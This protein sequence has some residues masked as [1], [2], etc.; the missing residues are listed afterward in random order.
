[1]RA[2]RRGVGSDHS[3]SAGRAIL[4]RG[5]LSLHIYHEKAEAAKYVCRAINLSIP[6][7]VTLDVFMGKNLSS[8]LFR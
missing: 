4:T 1:M 6:F 2:A 3:P 8:L 7:H 5:Y